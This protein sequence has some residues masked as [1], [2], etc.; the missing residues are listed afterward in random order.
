MLN[1]LAT[2]GMG[3]QRRDAL[4][5]KRRDAWFNHSSANLSNR[6]YCRPE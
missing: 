4:P 1:L 5:R 6:I 3:S 2:I